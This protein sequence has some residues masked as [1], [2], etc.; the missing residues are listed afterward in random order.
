M[1]F[2]SL[3]CAESSDGIAF[4]T[5]D[6]SE[7]VSY[8]HCCLSH[9]ISHFLAFPLDSSLFFSFSFGSSPLPSSLFSLHLYSPFSSS[10]LLLLWCLLPLSVSHQTFPESLLT[11]ALRGPL[12]SVTPRD[13]D[14]RCL[15]NTEKHRTHTLVHWVTDLRSDIGHAALSRE[16]QSQCRE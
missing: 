12:T 5:W 2:V 4:E 8:G 15:S 13:N 10:P 7:I 14:V 6:P 11:G 9:I 16:V 3:I 1:V